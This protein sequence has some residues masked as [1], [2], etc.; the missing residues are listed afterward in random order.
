VL[1]YSINGS[2]KRFANLGDAQTFTGIKTFSSDIIFAEQADHASTPSAGYGYLWVKSDT[3]SSL[4]FTDDAGTDYDLTVASSGDVESVGDCT[5]GAALDGSSDGGSYIRIYDGDS[6]YGEFQVPDISGNVTY[7]FPAATST[8]ATL[9]GAD[10]QVIFNNGGTAYAGD[11]GFVVTS[12]TDT[13]TLGE[14]GVDGILVLYN[15]SGGTDYNLIIQPG[16]Q[17]AAATITFPGSTSTLA[18]LALPRRSAGQRHSA[19]HSPL[20]MA[21]VQAQISS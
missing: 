3:P 14:N 19:L 11:A 15:E 10:T 5:S 8:I 6:H 7:T 16:T 20:T 1:S 17:S 9:Q 4:I 21:P 12:T 18:T 2:E 13:L